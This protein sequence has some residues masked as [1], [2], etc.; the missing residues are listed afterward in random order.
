M[1][2]TDVTPTRA[3]G[4]QGGG[5]ARS[6][7]R[8]R[9]ARKSASS[10]FPAP[11]ASSQP[12]SADHQPSPR[13]STMFRCPTARP[14]SATRSSSPRRSCRP[15]AI[16]SSSSITDGV[17]NARHRSDGDRAV[18]GRASHSGLYDRHRNA[19]RRPDSGHRTTRRRSTKMRCARTRK[20][21]A[22]RTRAPRMQRSCATR[23]RVS[24]A[25]RRSSARRSTRRWALRSPARSRHARRVFAGFRL[26][27]YPVN[28]PIAL[29]S[30]WIDQTGGPSR[31]DAIAMA[32]RQRKPR[33]G[34]RRGSCSCA[35]SMGAACDSLRRMIAERDAHKPGWRA[36]D[37]V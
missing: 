17:N 26:G 18:A 22:A 33:H 14:R 3:A 31:I 24:A 8:A 25:S 13:R 28:E 34:L 9:P 29:L 36:A 7:T 32:W 12:L 4:R 6:S 30:L 11:P 1:A 35:A 21:A 23:S 20:R 10:L 19:D 2:S 5:R 16:A 37:G 27:R 15:P